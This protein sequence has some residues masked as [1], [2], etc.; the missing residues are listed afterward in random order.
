MLSHS[1][2]GGE[3]PQEGSSCPDPGPGS[4]YDGDG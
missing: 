1:A 3:Q 2:G 4:G